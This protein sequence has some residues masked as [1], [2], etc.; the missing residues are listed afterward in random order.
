MVLSKNELENI[1]GGKASNAWGLG[2]LFS[3]LGTL[4]IGILDGFMRPLSCNQ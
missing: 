4:L 2:I 3:A 1:Q